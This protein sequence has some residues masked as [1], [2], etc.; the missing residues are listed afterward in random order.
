MTSSVESLAAFK[1]QQP[2]IIP[3]RSFQKANK[4]VASA[5]AMVNKLD[6]PKLQLSV[7]SRQEKPSKELSIGLRTKITT[8]NA[9][10][11]PFDKIQSKAMKTDGMASQ[12]AATRP[13]MITPPARRPLRLQPIEAAVVLAGKERVK[14]AISSSKERLDQLPKP[15]SMRHLK[16]PSVG[17]VRP[18]FPLASPS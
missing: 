5:T 10:M 17:S 7:R 3:Q 6:I 13:S 11:E 12:A 16:V 2:Q 14:G 9:K 4:R 18:Q 1:P 8:V 15:R